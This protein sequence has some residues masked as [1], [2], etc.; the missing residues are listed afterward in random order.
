LWHY[1]QYFL[2]ICHLSFLF[3]SYYYHAQCFYIYAFKFISLLLH[4][5]VKP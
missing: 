1:C 5:C 4:L 3:C 2:M